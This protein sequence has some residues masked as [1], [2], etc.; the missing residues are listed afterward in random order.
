MA[1]AR[2]SKNRG[3]LN[4]G[5][6]FEYACLLTWDALEQTDDARKRFCLQCDRPVFWC[7]DVDEAA[8]RAEQGECVAVPSAIVERIASRHEG[9]VVIMGRVGETK[10]TTLEAA[11]RDV[12]GE[13]L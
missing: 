1:D 3:I 12:L 2:Y 9:G 11:Y 7:H 10:R 6:R 13:E 8:L 4:C 5:V